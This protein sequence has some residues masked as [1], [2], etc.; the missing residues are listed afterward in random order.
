MTYYRQ[1]QMSAARDFIMSLTLNS[2]FGLTIYQLIYCS[3]SSQS[4]QL[5]MGPQ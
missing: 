2:I 4:P 1:S 3:V 5:V